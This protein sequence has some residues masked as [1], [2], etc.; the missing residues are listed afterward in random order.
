M[1]KLLKERTK[2]EALA[3][4]RQI[5][6]RPCRELEGQERDQLL[7]MFSLMEPEKAFNNQH[8]WTDVYMIGKTE[9]HV[10]SGPG[11]DLIV[12]VYEDE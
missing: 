10:S 5:M 2:E 6:G 12:E 4:V 1:Q 3:L 8:T 9:Y 7:T 11:I